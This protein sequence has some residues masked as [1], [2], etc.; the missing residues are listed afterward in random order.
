M[1]LVEV[2]TKEE[3]K[4]FTEI[5]TK[6]WKENE[7]EH[8]PVKGKDYVFRNRKGECFATLTLLKFNP[9]NQSFV[10]HIFQ[11]DQVEPIRSNQSSTIELDNFTILKDNRGL[12]SILSCFNETK[13]MILEDE[14]IKYTIGI[15]KPKFFRTLKMVLKNSI[16][17]LSVPI[18]YEND[19]CYFIPFY[20]D[21][22]SLRKRSKHVKELQTNA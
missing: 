6:G 14:E 7:W 12:K 15:V 10:N 8:F 11:F 18:Y 4:I 9:E 2:R 16:H 19:Q 5:L 21:V 1:P 20:V 13:K 17:S 22:D 3:E